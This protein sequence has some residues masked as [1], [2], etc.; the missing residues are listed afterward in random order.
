MST[1][2]STRLNL[3]EVRQ[4]IAY[5]IDREQNGF[6][7]LGES[8]VAVEYMTGMSD[9]LSDAWLSDE[10]LDSL[11]FYEQDLDLA[12]EL[13]TGLG[14]SRNDDGIWV[15]DNGDTLSFELTFPQEFADWSAAAENAT[16]HIE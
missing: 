10:T 6:V 14:F 11:N 13:L 12:E 1:T 5:V 15:D 3:V 4:A 7:S 16:A 2:V 8:G 9:G